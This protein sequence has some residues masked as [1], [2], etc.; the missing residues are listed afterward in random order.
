MKKYTNYEDLPL[1]LNAE[2]IQAVMNI[3]RAGAYT[4]MHRA[5]F[6]VI[7]IGKRMVVPRDKFLEWKD[8]NTECGMYG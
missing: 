3:S 4:L 7:R 6:P 8:Q 2:D 1:M 5:D